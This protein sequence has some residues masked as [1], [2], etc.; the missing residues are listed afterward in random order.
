MGRAAQPVG[1]RAGSG[2]AVVGLMAFSVS[3]QVFVWGAAPSS[4]SAGALLPGLRPDFGTV[5]AAVLLV[6]ELAL[7]LLWRLGEVAVW[8]LGAGALVD[9]V[10]WVAHLAGLHF[11]VGAAASMTAAF[12]SVAL[13][14]GIWRRPRR[15][16]GPLGDGPH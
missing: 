15:P 3:T 12:G 5:Y 11:P 8:V 13:G 16:L 7:C 9:L 4:G 2:A 14:A 6:V 10:F 1:R